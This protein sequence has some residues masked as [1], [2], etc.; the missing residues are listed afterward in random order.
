M[1]AGPLAELIDGRFFTADEEASAQ[2]VAILGPSTAARLFADEPPVGNTITIGSQTFTVVGVLTAVGSS[3]V[4]NDDD[5][6]VIPMT[7][8]AQRL[9]SS[10]DTR[11]VSAIYV[12]ARSQ[13]S[14][15]SA[16]QQITRAL[17]A[18]HQTTAADQDFTIITFEALMTAAETTTAVLTTLLSSIA[19][20]SLLV[21]GIGDEHHAGLGQRTVREIGLR[22]ALGATP[23]VIR[24][25]FLVEAGIVG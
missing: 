3:S 19:G 18:N 24:R 20:I 16:H 5:Q 9:S 2:Q 22:K 14:I 10:T 12:A 13:D 4:T 1:A 15:S 21:G 8:F 25:Q 6:V 11:A 23:A 17:V 7:T